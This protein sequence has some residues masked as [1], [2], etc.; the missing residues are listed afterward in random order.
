MEPDVSPLA[1]LDR[2]QLRDIT[3]NDEELMR[4]ALNALWDDTTENVCKLEQAVKVRDGERCVRLAH[5]SKGACANLGA[6]RAAAVFRAIETQARQ[7]EFER[8][9]ESL[10]ALAIALEELKTEIAAGV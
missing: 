2:D 10:S 5:Y 3:M 7:S 6:N 9:T 1:T 4:E 8:C